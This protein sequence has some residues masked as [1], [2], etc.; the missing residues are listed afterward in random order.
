M[1]VSLMRKD[2]H[3]MNIKRSLTMQLLLLG[4][5][6][7]LSIGQLGNLEQRIGLN[8]DGLVP[9]LHIL[10]ETLEYR[11]MFSNALIAVGLHA[12]A[13]V[14]CLYVGIPHLLQFFTKEKSEKNLSYLFVAVS[15]STKIIVAVWLFAMLKVMVMTLM[16]GCII[17]LLFTVLGFHLVWSIS[18]VSS[19][20]TIFLGIAAFLYLANSIV[21]AT[22]GNEIVL[23]TYRVMTLI[24]IVAVFPAVNLLQMD[25]SYLDFRYTVAGAL[26]CVIIVLLSQLLCT[27]FRKEQTV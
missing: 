14:F 2:L 1:L 7:V 8:I 3:T 19:L 18:I 13:I 5:F 4:L 23:K 10:N 9:L 11:L 17:L 12:S 6:L 15:K 21:W 20:L 25:F 26:F 22:N 16:N 27:L 24:G